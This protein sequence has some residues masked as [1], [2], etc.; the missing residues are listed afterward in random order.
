MLII[1]LLLVIWLMMYTEQ[2]DHELSMKAYYKGKQAVN[3]GAH[4]GT[5]QLDELQLSEGIFAIDPVMA[6][7][8]ATEYMY[9]NLRLDRNGNPTPQSFLKERVELLHFEVLDPSL[10]YPYEYSLSKYGYST[11]FNRP[12]VVIVIRM[13]YPRIFSSN[14][15]V[16]WNIIGSSQLVFQ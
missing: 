9:A 5:L 8:M 6:Y 13:K 12:A 15:P 11:T 7:Q 10:T 14:N 4:A 16:E 1:P 3:R 2:L